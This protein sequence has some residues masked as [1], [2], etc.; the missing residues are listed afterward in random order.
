MQPDWSIFRTMNFGFST[1]STNATH[2]H[3]Q[4]LDSKRGEVHDEVY[5][6]NWY[7]NNA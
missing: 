1:L 7:S 3:V 4:F 2:L 5:L 6:T